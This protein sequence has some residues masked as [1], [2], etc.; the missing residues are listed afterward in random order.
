MTQNGIAAPEMSV[1]IVT[2]DTYEEIATTMRYLRAQTIKERLEVVIVAPSA[3]KLGRD[4]TADPDFF[5]VRVVEVGPIHSLPLARALG[6]EQASAPIVTLAENHCF[7]TPMW[8]QAL[9]DAHRQPWAAVGPVL[10]NANPGSA[11]SWSQLFLTYGPWAMPAAGGVVDD[12]PGHNS[13]YKRDLLLEYGT[14]LA[15]MLEV[16]TFMH[17]DLR[18]KGYQ[19]YLEPAAVT[20]HVNVTRPL[21]LV[22]DHLYYGRMTSANK[23]KDWSAGRRLIGGA[24][25]LLMIPLLLWRFLRQARRPGRRQ[26]S[27]LKMVPILI[28]GAV[29]RG[30]GDMMGCLFGVGRIKEWLLDIELYRERHLAANDKVMMA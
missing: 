10:A 24:A 23:A 27:F 7:P 12:L 21:S 13:S 30:V 9:L 11:A 8:A 1:V 16:E 5:A 25:S 6:I 28:V 22:L 18:K 3:Q 17:Q 14:E 26:C 4:L 2:P 29:S 19:L 20:H 15:A